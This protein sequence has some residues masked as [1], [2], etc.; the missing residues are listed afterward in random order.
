[1]YVLLAGAGVP[2]QRT[3]YVIYLTNNYVAY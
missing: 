2:A 3:L 1:V